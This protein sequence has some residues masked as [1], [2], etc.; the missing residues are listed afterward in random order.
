M[1]PVPEKELPHGLLLDAYKRTLIVRMDDIQFQPFSDQTTAIGT[2]A[3]RACSVV[4]VA[5]R[6]GAILAHV[7][8]LGDEAT[9]K[10][11]DRFKDLYRKHRLSY[12]GAERHP[13]VVTG[14]IHTGNDDIYQEALP[15]MNNIINQRLELMAL[16]PS[17]TKYKFKVQLAEHSPQFPGKGTVLVDAAN[18]LLKIYVEDQLVYSS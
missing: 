18:E 15:D 7:A 13:W 3:L 6:V 16:Q 10:I 12:F 14:L 1:D 9:G 8:P 5:S 17:S 2:Y 11:M 4:I